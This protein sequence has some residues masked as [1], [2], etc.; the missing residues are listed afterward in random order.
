MLL[1]ASNTTYDVHAV[2]NIV[3]V[4]QYYSWNTILQLQPQGALKLWWLSFI[5]TTYDSICYVKNI[6]T[7]LLGLIF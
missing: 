4:T 5:S 1:I 2:N 7:Y 6:F 3:L